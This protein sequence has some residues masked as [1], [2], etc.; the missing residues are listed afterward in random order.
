MSMTTKRK[1]F[2]QI[3]LDVVKRATGEVVVNA[4]SEKQD[5][6]RKGGLSGG[7]KRAI[8]LSPMRRHEIAVK[9]AAARWKKKTPSEA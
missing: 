6:G 7:K 3:A 5:N 8:T 4:P 9:A 1:D 2:T